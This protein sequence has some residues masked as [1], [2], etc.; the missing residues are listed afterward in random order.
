MD[1]ASVQKAYSRWSRVYDLVF[2]PAFTRARRR[3]VS[4]LDPQIGDR[5][6]EVGVGT[7]L[8]FP[9]F[10]SHCRVFGVDISPEMLRRARRRARATG[11]KVIMADVS[12]LPFDDQTF[13]G[14]FAPYVASAVPDPVAMLR[15]VSRVSRPGARVVLVNHFISDNPLLAAAERAITPATS[16]L[17]GFHADFDLEP[18]L[19]QA[20]LR[21]ESS[22]RVPPLRYWKALRVVAAAEPGGA[23]T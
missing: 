11:N 6:L 12:H 14:V 19:D 1:L 5:I 7:G 9:E 22:R 18:V 2:G 21:V 13:D 17:L 15:E 16:R 3:A 23:R 10:P 4:M 8:S 20:G